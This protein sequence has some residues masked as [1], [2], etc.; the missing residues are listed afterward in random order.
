MN[1]KKPSFDATWMR[2]EVRALRAEEPGARAVEG[3]IGRVLAFTPPRRSSKASPTLVWKAVPVAAVVGGAALLSV[4]MSGTAK[5][6]SL[7]SIAEAVRAQTKR[8]SVTYRPNAEGKPVLRLEDWV[9]G[10][11]NVSIEPSDDGG[12]TIVGY[13][14]RL[15]FRVERNGEG[16]VDDVEDSGT[17]VESVDSYLHIPGAHL[18][19]VSHADSL[20]VYKIDCRTVVF[21]LYVDPT[22]RLPVRRDVFWE[23]GKFVERNEYD[24]PVCFPKGR[25]RAP[26]GPSITDYPALRR[27]LSGRLAAPGQTQTLGGITISLKAVL[28]SNRRLLALWTGGAKGDGKL[29]SLEIEGGPKPML[30]DRPKAFAISTDPL[31]TD[32]VPSVGDESLC[33]EGLW[34]ADLRLNTPFTIR[35]PVW[36]EDW[37]RPILGRGGKRLGFHS[38]LLGCLSFRVTNPIEVP[39]PDRVVWKPSNEPKTAESAD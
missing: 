10:A 33:G 16:F 20:D 36:A 2:E 5:A 29:R 25:F 23:N 14:G 22:T 18:F 4:A 8:H 37:S 21:D 17:P 12:R 1:P 9:D 35:V 31:A 26:S 34:Y 38:K 11:R 15:V 30:W 19:G 3:T 28:F 6:A 13:D 27:E 7:Q 39:G 24:Y 32:E